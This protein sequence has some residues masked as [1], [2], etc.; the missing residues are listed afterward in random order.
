MNLLLFALLAAQP[1][2]PP[3]VVRVTP[4]VPAPPMIIATTPPVPPPMIRMARPS[5]ATQPPLQLEVTVTG[6]GRTLYRGPLRVGFGYGASINE[7]AS[8]A[9]RQLCPGARNWDAMERR[10][11][12]LQL[13][14]RD[15]EGVPFVTAAV[16]W[17]R[18]MPAV[19]CG[20][21]G[22]RTVQLSQSA[23]LEPGRSVS[24]DG[25]AG[26]RVTLTRR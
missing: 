1:V 23:R 2:V 21:G 25:D 15:D 17:Q 3:P 19:A 10:S 22:S 4:V 8:E 14:M 18:P 11:L 20:A 7:Q 26:L 16:T 12:S 9:P 6:E 5:E 13:N 24:F